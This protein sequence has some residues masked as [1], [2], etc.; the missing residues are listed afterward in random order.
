[1]K[2][3]NHAQ[4]EQFHNK[5][6]VEL[7]KQT[8]DVVVGF[9]KMPGL[10]LYYGADSCYVGDKVPQYPAIYKLTRRYK[11]RYSFEQAVF[12]VKSQTLILS[13]SEQQKSE[14]QEHY[15][16]PNKR[17]HLLPPTLD[18]SFSPIT[19]RVTQKEKLRA[20][21][22]LPI[23]NLLLMFIG[24][25]FRT[26]GLARAIT[27]LADLPID[28][29]QR[30]SLIVV[31]HDDDEKQYRKQADKASVSQQILFLGGRSRQEIPKLLAAGDLMVHPAHNEN[32]GTVLLEAIA[33][34]LPVLATDVCGY[35]HHIKAAEAG[36]VLDSPFDQEALNSQLVSMLTSPYL[37]RWSAN[38]QRYGT[39]PAL[40]K[41]PTRAVDAIE[42]YEQKKVSAINST[43]DTQDIRNIYLREDLGE[44]NFDNLLD[45]GKNAIGGRHN[46]VEA[47]DKLKDE[48]RRT[49]SFSRNGQ[50]YYLKIHDGVGWK[51]IGKNLTSF[52][53]PVLGAENEWKGVHH[54]RRQ[55]LLQKFGLNTLN[56]AGYGTRERRFGKILNNP[57]KRQSLIVTDEIP[58]AISLEDLYKDKTFWGHKAN[59]TSDKIWFKRWLI[60]QLAQTAR[61]LHD[62][63][64]NHRDFYLSHFLLQRTKESHDPTPENCSLFLIDLHRMR[65][66]K[67]TNGAWIKAAIKGL[68][69]LQRPE[70]PQ[71]VTP[72][73][74]RMR[75]VS[76]LH[77]SSMDLGLTKRDLIRFISTYEDISNRQALEALQANDSFWRDVQSRAHNLYRSEKRRKR[78]TGNI[79]NAPPLASTQH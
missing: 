48:G 36:I 22:G 13:L 66:H 12:G 23:N 39:N 42:A 73:R 24:S 46:V 15:F 38:G 60:E 45:I 2:F 58:K 49:V 65:I 64:A 71:S 31:G 51:E 8:F 61:V 17:F 37:D 32:T 54:L 33:A 30:T 20:E 14:Y 28:L 69:K 70:I 56:I 27:A 26:K 21:L 57:A 43:D 68:L 5:L 52:K 3:S 77:Y 55:T 1:L 79:A 29:Q 78:K 40:Y 67:P 44:L 7:K 9:N 18:A 25:G 19:D 62:S 75:D 6:E 63:G 34:G 41:M 53:R 50:R 59:K 47:R 4:N 11:G 35:A 10:D 76:G 74:W 72:R 16:T